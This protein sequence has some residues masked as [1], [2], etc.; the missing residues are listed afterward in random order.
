M[1]DDPID[2]TDP[3]GDDRISDRN[4]ADPSIPGPN[5]SLNP[6]LASIT[7]TRGTGEFMFYLPLGA[8]IGSDLIN[9]ADQPN[10]AH[11][12]GRCKDCACDDYLCIVLSKLFPCGDAP[13]HGCKETRHL[14]RKSAP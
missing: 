6:D 4:P 3:T 13:A 2:G 8:P 14:R 5:Y 1:A 11:N 9:T 7:G 10:I 12:C